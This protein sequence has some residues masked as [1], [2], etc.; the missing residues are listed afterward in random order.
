MRIEVKGT[1]KR[2]AAVLV[3]AG[4]VS[5]GCPGEKPAVEEGEAPGA[6]AEAD[7][8]AKSG[9][10]AEPSVGIA[11]FG[12]PDADIHVKARPAA[13]VNSAVFKQVLDQLQE[14]GMVPAE[15]PLKQT[16][17]EE[18]GLDIDQIAQVNA[19]FT[20]DGKS[21]ILAALFKS[22]YDREA[23]VSKI[24]EA[25]G[26]KLVKV[27]SHDGFDLFNT[28]ASKGDNMVIVF[29]SPTLIAMGDVEALKSSLS[30]MKAG[31]AAGV[32]PAVKEQMAGAPEGASLVVAVPS[33]AKI[34]ESQKSLPVQVDASQLKDVVVAVTA[35]ENIDLWLR[36]NAVDA[37]TANK[38]RTE[39]QAGL[40]KAKSQ[41]NPMLDA[42][43]MAPLKD[44]LNSVKI[45]GT[46]V[47]VEVTATVR[48]DVV[49]TAPFLIGMIGPMM[50]DF[51][52]AP[53][54]AAGGG[55]DF[56]FDADFDD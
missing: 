37:D 33:V 9:A 46:G 8:K 32:P 28:E 52:M 22:P 1:W 13:L 45:G 23:L 29:V 51:M 38:L 15:K 12:M 48:P 47:T 14:M 25:D 40:D 16:I 4:I 35:A 42:P 39:A 20:S 21:L 41:P 43:A 7:A 50:M 53:P 55:E 11:A 18:T 56:D 34:A 36:M 5:F 27:D 26:S 30:N 10:K 44:V 6:G 54:P 24:E 2:L 3:V 31:R 49:K 17:Q 19:S